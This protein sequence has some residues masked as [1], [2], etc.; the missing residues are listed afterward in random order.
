MKKIKGRKTCEKKGTL[1]DNTSSVDRENRQSSMSCPIEAHSLSAIYSA[2][3]SN[4]A[5]K[6]MDSAHL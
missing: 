4:N 3:V 1:G 2:C 6:K 5:V